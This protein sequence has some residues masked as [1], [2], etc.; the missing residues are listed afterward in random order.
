ME[1]EE[2]TIRSEMDM[3]KGAKNL[4]SYVA[5]LMTAVVAVVG[6]IFGVKS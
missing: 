1:S 5:I 4:V 6:Y 2:K 3:M